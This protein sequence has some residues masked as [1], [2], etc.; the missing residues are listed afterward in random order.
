MSRLLIEEPPLVILPSLAKAV[1]LNES[2]ALQQ[3][4]YWLSSSQH[5]IDGRTWVYNTIDAWRQQFPFW[6]R[7]TIQRILS[8]LEQ[9][10]LILTGQYNESR[11]DHT[12]W[13]TIDY[14][15]LA[16][17]NGQNDTIDGDQNVSVDIDNLAESLMKTETTT[18]TNTETTTKRGT[19]AEAPKPKP[20]A[21]RQTEIT[22]EFTAAMHERF[23]SHFGATGVEERIEEALAHNAAKKWMDLQAYVRGWL[24]RDAEKGNPNQNG[25]RAAGRVDR[26]PTGDELKKA[27][28]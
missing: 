21:K 18:K 26:L 13:Y 4:H 24:R 10:G 19:G 15:R 6:S 16:S 23:D 20:K 27:W 14:D 5:Q 2:I 3:L 28:G 22:P 8:G 7:R 1:G 9:S 11:W 12:K 17:T 25:Y